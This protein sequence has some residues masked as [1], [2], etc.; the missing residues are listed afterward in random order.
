MR[1]KV[2]VWPNESKSCCSDYTCARETDRIF[3][4]GGH[5][6]LGRTP[7]LQANGM[8]RRKRVLETLPLAVLLETQTACSCRTR[9]RGPDVDCPNERQTCRTAAAQPC[10]EQQLQQQQ[11]ILPAEPSCL[12]RVLRRCTSYIL[13][14]LTPQDFFDGIKISQ[15]G[16]APTHEDF[17]NLGC[18]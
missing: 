14:D 8:E 13:D 7:K 3:F 2:F 11:A 15:H 4:P 6:G 12:S 16:Q 5:Q 10:Q 17:D 9:G 1:R 18:G